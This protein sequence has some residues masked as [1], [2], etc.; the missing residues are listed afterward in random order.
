MAARDPKT[1]L[2][3]LDKAL[4][5]ITWQGPPSDLSH[6]GDPDHLTCFQKMGNYK[7]VIS[8]WLV[9]KGRELV[10][11]NKDGASLEQ[12]Q[13]C[14]I[15]CGDGSLDQRI[16]SDLVKLFPSTTFHYMGTDA[17]DQ[18]CEVAESKLKGLAPNV[19][20][21]VLVKDYQELEDDD[22]A[23]R[24]D[25]VIMVNSISA[26]YTTSL[27]P[28]LKGVIHLLKPTGELVIISSSRQSFDEL[29]ARFWLHQQNQELQSTEFVTKAL[30]KL[31][32]KHNIYK[33]PLTFD[34]SQCFGDKF[35]TPHSQNI[36]DHLV[37]TRLKDYP[38]DVSELCTEYLEA[39]A[40][41]GKPE[42]YSVVSIS[43]MIVVGGKDAYNSTDA[44]K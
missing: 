42:K 14:S 41:P 37:L 44:Q 19:E 2:E 39:I 26:Y 33:E 38:P 32:V 23:T 18:I 5:K 17:D 12:F 15:G 7:D 10:K 22:I 6:L 30:D 40:E 21:E 25:L 3:D 16:L 4:D 28:L 11:L 20:V 36:L 43:D 27:E 8:K 24:F 13:I 1:I 34:L 9:Q 29:V 35:E 31:D